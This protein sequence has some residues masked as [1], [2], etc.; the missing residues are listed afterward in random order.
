MTTVRGTHK[1]QSTHEPDKK[2]GGAVHQ[3]SEWK[4]VLLIVLVLS[5]LFAFLAWTVSIAPEPT[6]SDLQYWMP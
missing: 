5:A 2:P 6:G 3:T 1:G 4:E